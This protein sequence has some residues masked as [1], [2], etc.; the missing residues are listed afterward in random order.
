[1]KLKVLDL[2]LI[3]G[4]LVTIEAKGLSPLEWADYFSIQ[5]KNFC[6]VNVFSYPLKDTQ[7]V[8]LRADQVQI[9]T[10]KVRDVDTDMMPL[11]NPF[12]EKPKDEEPAPAQRWDNKKKAWVDWEPE[13]N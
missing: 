10:N 11:G 7:E 2:R 9:V 13:K 12:V 3:D 6:L 1:M 8:Y 4:S 5:N